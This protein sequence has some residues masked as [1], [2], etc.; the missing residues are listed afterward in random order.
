MSPRP[1]A[2]TFPSMAKSADRA[3]SDDAAREPLSDRGI[4]ILAEVAAYLSAGLGSEDVLAQ[5]VGVLNRGLESD[6]CRVW[7]RTPDA[8]GYRAV[9]AEGRQT[10]ADVSVD[11]AHRWLAEDEVEVLRRGTWHLRRPL[12]HDGE[13]LGL[14]EAT[15]QEGPEAGT[16]RDVVSIVADVLSP[17]IASIELS[18]DLASEIAMRTREIESQRRFTAKII[19]SL[20]GRAVRHRSRLPHPG[21]EPQAGDR[22][23]GDRSG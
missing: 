13:R 22:H 4:R 10:P 8:A 17:L 9:V 7:V 5:V 6:A 11:E 20:P 18:E 12:V 19:D 21:V 2:G 1:G 23:A 14:L 16:L 15:M 3:T